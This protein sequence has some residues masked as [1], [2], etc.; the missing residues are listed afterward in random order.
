MD[1]RPHTLRP[2]GDST[3]QP[4]I[5]RLSPADDEIRQRAIADAER[6]FQKHRE[7]LRRLVRSCR[8]QREG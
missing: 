7:G 6:S 1:Y 2:V 8:G 5:K 3:P 4:P